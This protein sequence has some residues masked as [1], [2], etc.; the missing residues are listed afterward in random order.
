MVGARVT[1]AVSV[2][3]IVVGGLLALYGFLT[4]QVPS[5]T[6]ALL[7]PAYVFFGLMAGGSSIVNSLY[8]VFGYKGPREELER[9]IVYGVVFS[10]ASLIASFLAIALEVSQPWNTIYILLSLNPESRIAWMVII[11]SIYLVFLVVELAYFLLHSVSPSRVKVSKAVEFALGVLVLVV[12]IAA[13][14]NLAGIFGSTATIH[15]WHGAHL[16]A[17]FILW[18]IALGAAGQGLYVLILKRADRELQSF[19]ASFYGRIMTL[20]LLATAAVVF[21]MALLAG[22]GPAAR[23]WEVMLNGAYSAHFWIGFVIAG[24]AAPIVLSIASTTTRNILY[25]AAASI[26]ALLGGFIGMY[27]I[28]VAPQTARLTVFRDYEVIEFA[29]HAD[30]YFVLAGTIL[31]WIGIL[32]LGAIVVK[33]TYER[34]HQQ[35]H[36]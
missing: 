6:W 15:M 26:L 34:A 36:S 23:E 30:E 8:T 31:I 20:G 28:V 3:L 29:P 32:S 5:I 10:L 19:A 1:V 35:A 16:A 11:Y 12:T 2:A 13:Y 22:Y 18:A 33:S 17:L 25:Q 27:T 4:K 21:W 24:L 7:V 14:T 9:I